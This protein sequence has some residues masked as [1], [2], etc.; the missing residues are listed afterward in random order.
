MRTWLSE[1][2]WV[3]PSKKAPLAVLPR[4]ITGLNKHSL[5]K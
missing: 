1:I 3:E 2:V 5:C 4:A